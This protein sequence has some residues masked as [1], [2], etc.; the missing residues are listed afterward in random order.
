MM[1]GRFKIRLQRLFLLLIFI[2]TTPGIAVALDSD[3]DGVDDTLD[4][5]INAENTDQRDSNGDGFGNACDADLD[6]SGFVNFADLSLFKSA[7]G[8][9]DADADFDGSGLVN[10]ADLSAFKL[11]FGQPP[12]PSSNPGSLSQADAARFLTQSTFGPTIQSINH[13]VDVGS[14][15]AWLDE[16]FAKPATLQL[17]RM[18]TFNTRMC[19]DN[20]DPE[21]YQLSGNPT[22]RHNAWWETVITGDD[23]LR[24]R[25]AF[26][27]SEILVISDAHNFTGLQFGA[28]DYHDILIR[29]AFGNY[30]DL[31]QDV[32]LHPIMGIFLSMIK[33]EKADPEKNIR[34]D[35]NFARELM[36][37]FT[38]GIFQLQPNGELALDNGEPVPV[39]NQAEIKEFARVFTG[40]TYSG[41]TYWWENGSILNPMVS[42]E[43]HHD[44]GEKH[45]LNDQ[46]LAANQTA[47]EDLAAALDNVFNHPNTGPFIS[48]L[49]IQRLVTSNPSPNYLLRVANRFNDNGQGVRGDLKAVIKAI[50]LDPEARTFH[51]ENQ[52]TG[53]LREPLL[54]VSHVFRAFNI[55]PSIRSGKLW[56]RGESCGQ[57]SYP[58]YEIWQALPDYSPVFG[59]QLLGA[60]SVFNFFLPSYSP[61]GPIRDAHLVA[62]DFQIA[63]DNLIVQ[64][65]NFINT[66]V[67]WVGQEPWTLDGSIAT[68]NTDRE[69]AMADNPQQLVDH[70]DLL[71]LNGRMTNTLREL[72]IN[73]LNTGHFPEDARKNGYRARETIMLILNS[74]DYLVQQ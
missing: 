12:G 57:P 56:P 13:L 30:R 2:I 9:N 11:M 63:T 47:P 50:L 49:L 10:F 45:L 54:R 73:H 27:L 25:V 64:T 17:P 42:W 6:N 46:V 65:N 69:A 41:T 66:L 4:N 35:E 60:P 23:Q 52:S 28:A 36:Q 38:V 48:K 71:L 8:S 74:P 53:K 20:P 24:Q 44:L 5:C 22:A 62:P 58:V 72:L 34:P 15:E 3:G 61:Q 55:Q 39:Y 51:P 14:Y 37:L 33:N 70:L 21:F 18:Q 32:T 1:I 19:E 7:F 67:L 26:A 43:D 59:Q 68:I 31:L 40:W 29:H 16:Q